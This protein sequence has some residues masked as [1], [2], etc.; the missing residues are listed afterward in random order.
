MKVTIFY[1][2]QSDLPNGTNRSLIQKALETAAGDL[3]NDD[4]IAVEPVVDRD[5]A[6]IPGSPDIADTILRKIDAADI[7]VADVS[8][9]NQ[10]S[11]A[12]PTPNPNV[13]IE[14]GYALKSLGSDR[15][16]LIQNTAFGD[17]DV[18]PF[19][20]KRKRVLAYK[21]PEATIDRSPIRKHL[22]ASLRDALRIILEQAEPKDD[23]KHPV[24]L[25][26]AYTDKKIQS[27]RHDYL[28]LVK[29]TNKGTK[30]ISEWHVDVQFP[31]PL[32]EPQRRL[33]EVPERNDSSHTFLRSTQITH[34]GLIYPGDTKVVMGIDY[35]I[36]NDLYT[37]R[38]DLFDHLIT[39]TAYVD[40]MVA[41]SVK[42]PVREFQKF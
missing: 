34:P 37:S 36:D 21:C 20:L 23:S 4:S 27:E 11:S 17:V 12:R 3:R 24:E 7:V 16:I 14:L 19:D 42:T 31:T 30:P 1:S 10:G 15:L 28:L 29:L 9:I 5:T 32:L 35:R 25:Q 40:G 13:L 38:G 26:I 39:A 22:Q 18:L 6:N 33:L 8:I 2:W 41:A